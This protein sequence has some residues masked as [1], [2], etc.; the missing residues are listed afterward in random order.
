MNWGLFLVLQKGSLHQRE[1]QGARSYEM[2]LFTHSFKPSTPSEAFT[3]FSPAIEAFF[4]NGRRFQLWS[5]WKGHADDDQS[6]YN[7]YVVVSSEDGTEA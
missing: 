3:S 4:I 6:C 2:L 5:F 7:N 1:M